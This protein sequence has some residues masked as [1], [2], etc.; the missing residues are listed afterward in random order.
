MKD[1]L[2][3]LFFVDAPA[4]GAFAGFTLLL[5]AF[6]IVPALILLS[7]DFSLNTMTFLATVVNSISLLGLL[8]AILYALIVWFRFYFCCYSLT[9]QEI[10][11]LAAAHDLSL[12]F[13]RC[14]F[15]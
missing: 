10:S 7:G 15:A 2:K 4:Q 11:I 9:A 5:A 14:G 12:L 1:F 8:F 6:W 3:K 13:L